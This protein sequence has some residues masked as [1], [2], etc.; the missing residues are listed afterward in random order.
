[1]PHLLRRQLAVNPAEEEAAE[2][3]D[4]VQRGPNLV[5]HVR[6]EARFQ[7]VSPP[8]VYGA[9]V[10]LGVEGDDPAIGVVQLLVDPDKVLLPGAQVGQDAEE[11]TVLP[12][13]LGE[14]VVRPLAGQV[15]AQTVE[16]GRPEH[17]RS[18]WQELAEGDGCPLC[19]RVNVE[20]IDEPPGAHEPDAH[21]GQGLVLAPQDPGQVRDARASIAH[22][23]QEDLGRRPALDRKVDLAAHGVRVGVPRD[24]GGRRR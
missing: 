13:K 7:L 10:Q 16:V 19:G 21:A 8:E 12:L 1:L 6:E 18:G 3:E 2:R 24:L 22:A 11:L 15:P 20:P 14:R 9:F 4:R 17:R 5:A 23:N